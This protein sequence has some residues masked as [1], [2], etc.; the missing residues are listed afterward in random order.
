MPARTEH[1]SGTPSWVDLQTSDQAGAK[2]F[3][4]ALF[5]W[6]YDDQPV[7]HDADGNEA[8]YSMAV[9]FGKSV[10][11][12]APVPMPD[13]P[14]HWNTYVTVTDVDATAAQ[15]PGAGGTMFMEPFDVMDAGRMAV[16]ADPTGAML[17]LWTPKNHIG[18]QLVNEHGTLSWT[19]LM[20]PD[21]PTA[22]DF[23]NQI[24]GW[25][26]SPIEMPGMQY[27]EFKL[28]DRTI[29]GGMAPPMDGMLAAW[30]I[31]FAVDDTDKVVEIA[32]SKGASVLQEP[33]DIPPGRMAVLADPAGAVFS[34]I[35]MTQPAD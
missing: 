27:T 20:S 22:A 5:G 4:S 25:I 3:Y 12:I 23:Y 24:F 30:G 26:A 8:V 7:G 19:E 15:V 34:V 16:I 17:C 32:K 31:Y 11:A 2:S 9:K 29:A 1:A 35:K 14:P 21:V 33:T 10:A 13:V 28:N 18:A 6:D